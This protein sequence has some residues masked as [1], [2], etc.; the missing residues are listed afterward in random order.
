MGFK[1]SPA[2]KLNIAENNDEESETM[3]KRGEDGEREDCQR[4]SGQP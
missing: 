3:S 4:T 2:H 1:E